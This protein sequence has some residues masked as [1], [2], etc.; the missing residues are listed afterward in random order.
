LYSL[1]QENRTALAIVEQ[2]FMP[3]TEVMTSN[4]AYIRLEGDRRKLNG[5]L[6]KVEIDRT[7]DIK[8]WAE[9]IKKWSDLSSDIFVYFSKF[10]SG[11]P[12]TD[13]KQ[14][15]SLLQVP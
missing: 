2:P 15:T 1:L 10:Y 14:L 9:K 7:E 12:P 11:H 8:K 6:G 3:T 5:T 4:F 13:A